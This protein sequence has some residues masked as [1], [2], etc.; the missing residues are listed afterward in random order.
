VKLLWSSGQS[1]WLQTQRP[2]LRFSAVPDF[3]E[4]SWVWNGVHSAA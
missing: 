3:S 2:Q 4:W 1:A